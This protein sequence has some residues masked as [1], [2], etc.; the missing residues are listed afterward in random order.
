M[1]GGKAER[2]S[3]ASG[4]LTRALRDYRVILLDQRGTGRSTPANRRTLTGRTPTEQ[5]EFLTHFR[6]DNIVQDAEA[7]RRYL[8]GFRPCRCSDRASVG[9]AP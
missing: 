2:P 3:P 6:A 9:S 7:L 5:A 4:W 1:Q 8:T